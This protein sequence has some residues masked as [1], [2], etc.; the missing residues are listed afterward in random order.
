MECFRTA[1]PGMRLGGRPGRMLAATTPKPTRGYKEFRQIKRLQ[2]MHG[3]M[4]DNRHLSDDFI[5]EQ[6]ELFGGT[7]W[8]DQELLGL[9]VDDVVGALYQRP[10]IKR[11]TV[12]QIAA[13]GGL[14]QVVVSVDPSG[15]EKGLGDEC[16]IIVTGRGWDGNGYLLDDRSVQGTAGAWSKAIVEAFN[17]AYT[18]DLYRPGIVLVEGDGNMGGLTK[19]LLGKLDMNLPV[20]VVY[21]GGLSKA[22]R[23]KAISPLYEQG[24][25]Y[26]LGE[27]PS[28]EDEMCGWVPHESDY[29]PNR[30]D[31]M[32][33]GWWHHFP[34]FNPT[35]PQ[36]YGR[37]HRRGR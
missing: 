25:I 28:L 10:W 31:A 11:G 24:R 22:A 34:K 15:S 14:D 36:R 30:L 19:E 8:E 37:K 20:E 9:L 1:K 27:F 35:K 18:V 2:F 17:D 13:G 7:Q 5:N 4:A 21:T 26:H 32:V 23:A 16:G 33:Y 3:T 6:F 29:S 12:H